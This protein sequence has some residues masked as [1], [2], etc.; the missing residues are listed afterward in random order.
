MKKIIF[1]IVLIFALGAGAFLS[2]SR[3]TSP[4]PAESVEEI[5]KT[6]PMSSYSFEG[7]VVSLTSTSVLVSIGGDQRQQIFTL[8]PE[9]LVTDGTSTAKVA[10]AKLSSRLH[11]G[12]RAVFSGTSVSSPFVDGS[13]T[14]LRVAIV[15]KSGTP[16]P[17]PRQP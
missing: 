14:V 4:K 6:V 16:L 11:S 5:V 12:D 7:Q 8:S 3:H 13:L 10:A 15:S 9:I 17:P 2:F 1:A